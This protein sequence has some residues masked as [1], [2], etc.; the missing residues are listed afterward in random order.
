MLIFYLIPSKLSNV[1]KKIHLKQKGMGFCTII[2]LFHFDEKQK[3]YFEYKM[4]RG[5]GG[6]S[7]GKNEKVTFLS[8][9][10]TIFVTF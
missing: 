6:K 8:V 3:G 9:A 4:P 5:G 1:E 2:F 7:N 10:P